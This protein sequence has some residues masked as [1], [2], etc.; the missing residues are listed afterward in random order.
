MGLLTGSRLGTER[1]IDLD[2]LEVRSLE[3]CTGSM[4]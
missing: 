2:E 3:N 1:T 4:N